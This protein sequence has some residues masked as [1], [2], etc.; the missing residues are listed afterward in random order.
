MAHLGAVRAC[1]ESEAQ[2]NPSLKGGVTV[3]WTIDPSGGVSSAS[4]AGST[5]GNPRVEGCVVRQVKGW[6]FPSTETPTIVGGFP[7]KF[8]VGG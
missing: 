1:Y 6:H 8:G 4:L 7:F 2:R 3:Q 5:L